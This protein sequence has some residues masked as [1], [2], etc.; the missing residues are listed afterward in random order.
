M[1]G[2]SKGKSFNDRLLAG[3]VRSLALEHVKKILDPE[4]EDKQFQKAMLLKLATNILP[5]LN[6]HTGE[7]GK[8]LPKPLL[9]VLDNDSNK[10]DS[11]TKEED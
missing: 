11:K 10:E 1:K 2:G 7:D 5:R 8:E 3:E 9:Y 6:E 4:Y